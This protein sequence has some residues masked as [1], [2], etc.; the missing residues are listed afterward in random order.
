MYD[1]RTLVLMLP[2]A[3]VY[4]LFWWCFSKGKYDSKSGEA[5]RREDLSML[6]FMGLFVAVVVLVIIVTT[7]GAV[8][9]QDPGRTYLRGYVG[10]TGIAPTGAYIWDGASISN[11]VLGS[12]PDGA[13]TMAYAWS[14]LDM[15]SRTGVDFTNF[16]GPNSGMPNRTFPS[17][18]GQYGFAQ[19]FS[20]GDYVDL[21]P[22][23]TGLMRFTTVVWMRYEYPGTSIDAFVVGTDT[24]WMELAVPSVGNSSLNG[25]TVIGGAPYGSSE[26]YGYANLPMNGTA[27]NNKWIS[28]GMSWD[29]EN[30]TLGFG[31]VGITPVTETSRIFMSPRSIDDPTVDMQLGGLPAPLAGS[32]DQIQGNVDEFVMVLQPTSAEDMAWPL[33]H[34][35]LASVGSPPQNPPVDTSLIGLV[36]VGA[37][38]VGTIG[39]IIWTG[40][41]EASW[42]RRYLRR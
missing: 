31:G 10:V 25:E 16:C 29:G 40:I 15:S 26:G 36:V 8:P 24:W 23:P 11:R 39:V 22:A 21:G 41:E 5:R 37:A 38:I 35:S 9:T 34:W 17:A 32:Y 42:W 14:C 27:L 7:A 13:F 1:L 20:A 19:Q 2:L 6:P 33:Q 12:T 18:T 28:L 4:A 3:V 30:L